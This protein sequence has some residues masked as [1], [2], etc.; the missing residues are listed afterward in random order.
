LNFKEK[1]GRDFNE[2]ILKN[3]SDLKEK[4]LEI[5]VVTSETLR[6]KWMHC[7]LTDDELSAPIVADR[8]GHLFNKDSV[9]K[10][11][12]EKRMPAQFA[13]IQ[14]IKDVFELHFHPNASEEKEKVASNGAFHDFVSPWDCPITGRPVN[15]INLFSA[16]TTCGHVFSD[17]G[18]KETESAS[19]VCAVCAE[20][21]SNSDLLSLNPAPEV[22][23][24]LSRDLIAKHSEERELRK[25]RKHEEGGD[26]ERKERAE[27]E[28]KHKKR[29][30][31]APAPSSMPHVSI[32]VQV[33]LKKAET[34]HQEKKKTSEA[35]T[36]IFGSK[37]SEA[38][39]NFTG[40]YIH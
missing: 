2:I 36:A 29:R 38:T 12:L 28:P 19:A 25:K 5:K 6:A 18:L 10:A 11:L 21:F 15:G 7:A 23:A 26:K 34:L 8:V 1:E 17:R 30:V 27:G 14:A 31:E 33:A 24:A 35:Y 20:P 9:I 16:L 39:S 4:K 22:A 32:G 37:K 13:H 3:I 40:L